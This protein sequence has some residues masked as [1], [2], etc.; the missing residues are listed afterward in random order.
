MMNSAT[1][2]AHPNIALVKYWGK[3]NP[4]LNL[5]SVPSLSITLDELQSVTL[6]EPDHELAADTCLLNGVGNESVTAR[7]SR[8]L[9]WFR[10]LAGSDVHA[11]VS[12]E[13]NFPTAA[14]L[15]SSAAGFA[16]LV[17]A[18]NKVY[19]TGL[20][21]T[22]MSQLARQASGSAGRSLFGGFVE[23]N[24]GTAADGSDCRAIQVAAADHWPLEIVIAITSEAEK[25]TGSSEGMLHSAATSDYF[26][27][28]THTA[29]ANLEEARESVL[30]RD[31]ERLAAVS[32]SSCLKM[33][34]VMLASKPALMYWN[35]ATVDCIAQVRTL[36]DSGIGVFFTIDAGPQ[37]KAVC[38]PGHGE[39]AAV[40]LADIQGVQ[41]IMRCGLG[42]GACL[43]ET[44]S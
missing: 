3:R 13:N 23:Q 44:G 30:N 6:V 2:Q 41:R 19:E 26:S 18:A 1:A 10:D 31:F 11:R 35:S 14:G 37:V 21:N 40:A 29:G 34:A 36:R 25:K 8:C 42:A 38:L 12:S 33:H 4:V 22:R 32:E 16:A 28:W 39:K 9:Q 27:G 24:L 43:A 15:A 7:V 20:D 5:P 17:V